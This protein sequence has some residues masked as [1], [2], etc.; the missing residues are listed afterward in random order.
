MAAI[1][2]YQVC[3]LGYGHHANELSVSTVSDFQKSFLAVQE[4]YFL[5]AVLTKSSLLFLYWRIFGVSTRFRAALGVAGFFVISYFVICVTISIF[6]CQPVSY[7]WDKHQPGSGHCIQEVQFFRF[8]GI[9]NMLLDVMVLLL[10]IPM[11]WKLN[12]E[13][14]QKIAVTGMFLLGLL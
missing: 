3:E 7:F 11:V 13:R 12:L 9:T 6:G 14:Q 8:N 10:P 5:N 4:A 2:F 1:R